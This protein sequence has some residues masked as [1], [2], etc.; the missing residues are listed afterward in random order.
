[1]SIEKPNNLSKKDKNTKFYNNEF[2]NIKTKF[3]ENSNK[4]YK[5]EA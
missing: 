1:M 5:T 4:N 3:I 2:N